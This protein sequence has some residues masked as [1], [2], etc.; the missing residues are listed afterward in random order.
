M[1][2]RHH[3]HSHNDRNAVINEDMEFISTI[4][5]I[6]NNRMIKNNNS[7]YYHILYKA[8][9]ADKKRGKHI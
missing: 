9:L 7:K 6:Y 3:H 4:L 1:H 5:N 2:H 8:S